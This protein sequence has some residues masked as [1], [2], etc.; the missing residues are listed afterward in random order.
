MRPRFEQMDGDGDGY[1]EPSEIEAMAR[2][3]GPQGGDRVERMMR[4]DANADGKI[5]RDEAPPPLRQRFDRLDSDGDGLLS[6]EEIRS[7]Q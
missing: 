3:G 7:A 2:R 6:P 1:V 4:S 5:S